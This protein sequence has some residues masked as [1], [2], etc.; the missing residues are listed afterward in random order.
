VGALV[1]VG[2]V[3]GSLVLGTIEGHAFGDNVTYGAK[4]GLPAGVLVGLV[5]LVVDRLRARRATEG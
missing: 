3:V 5:L 2:F 4:T 1:F